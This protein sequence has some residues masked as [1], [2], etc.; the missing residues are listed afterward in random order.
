MKKILQSSNPVNP[1]SDKHR[2]PCYGGLPQGRPAPEKS[3]AA[4]ISV[5]KILQ[6]SNPVNPDSDKLRFPCYGG[7]PQ[8]RPAWEIGFECNS[9]L[10]GGD[11]A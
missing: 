2:V 1:D 5:N 6:S 9:A 10:Y 11:C 7:S 3:D 8:G 4:F